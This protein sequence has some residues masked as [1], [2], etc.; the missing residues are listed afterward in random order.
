MRLGE[1]CSGGRPFFPGQG[2]WL[3]GVKAGA[4]HAVLEEFRRAVPS[5]AIQA[6]WI[7]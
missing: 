2:Q 7:C 6:D 5:R 1:P 3:G 4:V